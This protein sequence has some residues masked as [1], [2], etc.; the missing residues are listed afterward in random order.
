MA[1]STAACSTTM[2]IS[3]TAAAWTAV[4]SAL[5]IFA[6]MVNRSI[7]RVA[8]A[9]MRCT[10]DAGAKTVYFL[11]RSR[12]GTER[13]AARRTGAARGAPTRRPGTATS[14]IADRTGARHAL[15]ALGADSRSVGRSRARGIR[16]SLEPSRW[17][18]R[19]AAF[20]LGAS[21][22][23]AGA[24]IVERL[25][26]DRSGRRVSRAPDVRADADRRPWDRHA[27]RSRAQRSGE[28]RARTGAVLAGPEGRSAAVRRARAC[29]S[30]PTPITMCG[31]RRCSRISQLPKERIGPEV[32]RAREDASRSRKSASRRC[33]GWVSPAT[34]ARWSSSRR[35]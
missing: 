7:D 3:A 30:T 32:D 35:C 4:P 31:S 14:T 2:A 23:A 24:A 34:R 17:L 6:R 13:R 20:W 15:V 8:L 33:S 26:R 21:R 1:T 27:D 18:R 28:Q 5:V 29:R 10:V 12:A 19:D 25:A 9:D 16:R 11:E 22:G